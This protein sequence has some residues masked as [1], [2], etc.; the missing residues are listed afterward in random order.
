VT[1][2]GIRPVAVAALLIAPFAAAALGAPI[3]RSAA[4]ASLARAAFS[5][6]IACA[7]TRAVAVSIAMTIAV[8]RVTASFAT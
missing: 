2:I 8:T 7:I 6:A 1:P 4:F 3:I 5:R